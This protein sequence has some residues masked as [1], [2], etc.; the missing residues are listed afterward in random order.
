MTKGLAT[1]AGFFEALEL[2]QKLVELIKLCRCFGANEDVG[3][4]MAIGATAGAAVGFMRTAFADAAV[5]DARGFR[6]HRALRALLKA[7][8]P[9]RATMEWRRMRDAFV[10]DDNFERSWAALGRLL[11]TRNVI[12]V[13]TAADSLHGKQLTVWD[14]SAFLH[15]IED[16]GPA[17]AW[18]VLYG[19]S[20]RTVIAHDALEEISATA[21]P[22]VG[23]RLDMV[24]AMSTVCFNC[25]QLGHFASEYP[26]P[27]KPHA[28]QQTRVSHYVRPGGDR[29]GETRP[30][31]FIDGVRARGDLRPLHALPRR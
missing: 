18:E 12:P 1:C 20:A 16:A 13:L 11:D 21:D 27:R 24:A 17:W 14:W 5:S 23:G 31:T 19:V 3:K 15:E 4:G 26:E 9:P 2:I 6:V 10:W 28:P 7:H 29:G 30:R 8:L 22:G 25:K